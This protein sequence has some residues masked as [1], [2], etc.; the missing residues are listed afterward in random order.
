MQHVIDTYRRLIAVR[1]RSQ[2]QYR[3][4]TLLDI[5]GMAVVTAVEFGALAL[6]FQRFESIAGW[7]LGEVAFLYGLVAAAFGT[8]DLI[9][10][11]FDP[12]TFGPLVQRGTLDQLLLRPA[13]ITL[14]VLGSA[15]LLRRFGKIAQGIVIFCVAL[16]M[17]D[18]D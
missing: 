8:T 7:T 11:G 6:V 5:A 3:V 10:G 18:G 9:F 1:I 15:F 17:T 12:D 13:N 16:S 4:S 14:Q 2:L